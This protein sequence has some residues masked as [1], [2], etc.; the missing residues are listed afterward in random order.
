MSSSSCRLLSGNYKSTGTIAKPPVC[1]ASTWQK[2]K[3]PSPSKGLSTGLAKGSHPDVR[4]LP[5][6][7]R[8]PDAAEGLNLWRYCRTGHD[9]RRLMLLG[10]QQK[11]EAKMEA[12]AYTLR[13]NGQMTKIDTM[14]IW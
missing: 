1:R 8:G 7:F 3:T 9:S 4:S 2:R 14:S 10:F 6:P 13:N 5:R 11:H 12:A